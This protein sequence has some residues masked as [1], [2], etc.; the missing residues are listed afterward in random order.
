MTLE[1]RHIAPTAPDTMSC[2]PMSSDLFIMHGN[3]EDSEG[4]HEFEGPHIYFSGNSDSAAVEHK[5][6]ANG[7]LC[8]TVPTFARECDSR[9][10]L[11]EAS[12]LE[13]EVITLNPSI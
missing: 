1:S 9:V 6:A 12:T 2:N 11:V 4:G 3:W 10:V 5:K 7:T 8:L 13:V